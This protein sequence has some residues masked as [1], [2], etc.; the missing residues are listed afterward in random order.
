MDEA[1][2]AA[3]GWLSNST[4]RT[5]FARSVALANA[6]SEFDAPEQAFTVF[7]GLHGHLRALTVKE[8]DPG[9]FAACLEGYLI[10]KRRAEGLGPEDQPLLEE[11]SVL[12]P[13]SIMH[14]IPKH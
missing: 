7:R 13:T 9:L 8:W 2:R 6:F 3:A 14:V 12:D 1:M 11:L 4:G 10:S 5:R